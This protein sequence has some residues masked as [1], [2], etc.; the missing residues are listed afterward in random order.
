MRANILQGQ[1]YRERSLHG[2]D[3]TANTLS[4]GSM[5]SSRLTGTVEKKKKKKEETD[6][7]AEFS[8]E[9]LRVP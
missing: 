7:D 4:S 2:P 5:R 8:E 1:P 3:M 9:L 6:D